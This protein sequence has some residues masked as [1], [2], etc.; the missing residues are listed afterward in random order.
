MSKKTR[1]GC[2]CGK[3]RKKNNKGRK[4]KTDIKNK[5]RCCKEEEREDLP[6]ELF[7]PSGHSLLKFVIHLLLQLM[8]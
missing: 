2:D 6:A 5:Q 8:L 1:H 3:G 7:N 4:K